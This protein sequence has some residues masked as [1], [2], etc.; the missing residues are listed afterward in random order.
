MKIRKH[1]LTKN[2]CYTSG[3]T[4]TPKGIMVHS[5]GVAQ[6][7]VNVFLKSWNTAISKKCVHAFVTPDEVVQTLPWNRRGWHAGGKANNTHIS[8]E[9]LE[10]SGHRYPKNSGAMINYDV[11]KNTEYFN[12]IYQQTVDLCAFLCREYNLPASSVIT[13]AEG[14]K[15]GI[16]TNHADVMHWFPKH[17]KSMNTLRADID[18]QL[19]VPTKT[20]TPASS[21]ADITWLQNQLNKL[22]KEYTIEVT[23]T[24]DSRT[25]IAVL[26]YWEQLGW[27]RHMRDNGLAV[28]KATI[29]ALAQGRRE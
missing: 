10:P 25:R 14:F 4:I 20:I 1:Y 27:G 23:G 5:L 28:G 9:L 6:P 13:H 8:M 24:Y 3:K 12:K 19:H 16:A 15:I 2:R 18:A 7:D 26:L 11:A 22:V 21:K 17:G 29:K